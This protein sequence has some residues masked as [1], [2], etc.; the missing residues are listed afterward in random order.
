MNGGNEISIEVVFALP[1]RQ[2]LSAVVIAAGA[3]PAMALQLSGI[4]QQFPEY[5]FTG[6]NFA[7]WGKVVPADYRL[8]DGDRLEVLR[9]LL[10]DP[11]EARRELAKAGQFMG[12]ADA[13]DEPG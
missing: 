13:G 2:L 12:V 9:P 3:S 7:V 8:S 4:A 1:G 11:R 6:C 5:D 10:I